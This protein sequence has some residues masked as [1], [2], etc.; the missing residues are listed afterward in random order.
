MGFQDRDYYREQDRYGGP[1]LLGGQRM[2]ATN[3]VI[4]N[5]AI[6]LIDAFTRRV[7]FGLE[8]RLEFRWLSYLLSLDAGLFSRHWE[9]WRLLTYGFAHAPLGSPSGMWHVGMNMLMLWMFGR[10]MEMK[11][12]RREFLRFYLIA[13]VVAG[14]AWLAV[15]NIVGILLAARNPADRTL[16]ASGAVTAVLILFILNYP[17]RT[18]Y[19][20]GLLAVPAWLLGVLYVGLDTFGFLGGGGHVAY[21][22]HLGGAAFALAYYGMGWNFERFSLGRL[23]PPA[24]WL[25]SRPKL[26]VH[27]PD[28]FYRQQDIEADR[29]L[30]K[31]HR[32][33]Q[34]SLTARERR[35]LEEY[36]R[37]MR[38]KHRLQTQSRAKD[39]HGPE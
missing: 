16:G 11:Y 34:D 12:G 38:Q 13:I 35:I 2:M 26:K 1:A 22:A 25:P 23:S 4:L 10:D 14:L 39:A 32:Q 18:L 29:I 15:Q 28:E 6:F 17:R 8:G 36:S 9:F 24:R 37:R 20:W 30:D 27:D 7:P 3:L 5:V 33:G 31:V 21:E 19:L